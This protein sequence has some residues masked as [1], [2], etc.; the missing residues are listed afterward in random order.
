MSRWGKPIK[1]KRRITEASIKYR[2][3]E[4][5]MDMFGG[6]G[7]K[8]PKEIPDSRTKGLGRE[9]NKHKAFQDVMLAMG[10]SEPLQE[11]LRMY[12]DAYQD[13]QGSEALKIITS[14]AEVVNS[15]GMPPDEEMQQFVQQWRSEYKTVPEMGKEDQMNYEHRAQGRMDD[16][17]WSRM[18]FKDVLVDPAKLPDYRATNQTQPTHGSHT[19]PKR[20]R[21]DKEQAE[22]LQFEES[23]R[24]LKTIMEG[25]RKYSE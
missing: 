24:S 15:G 1:N 14:W 23:K 3:D 6:S 4:G 25:F 2:L 20:K 22:G 17:E 18:H 19:I 7:S 21:W 9:E 16:D 8:G 10:G 13:D 5:I 11:P 12:F